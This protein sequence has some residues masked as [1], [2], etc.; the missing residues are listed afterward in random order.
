MRIAMLAAVELNSL[1]RNGVG[2]IMKRE[3]ICARQKR[4]RWSKAPRPR[5][6]IGLQRVRPE[7]GHHLFVRAHSA[8]I[9]GLVPSG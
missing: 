2:K 3:W 9:G 6:Q 5:E 7:R 4:L 8:I 1:Y